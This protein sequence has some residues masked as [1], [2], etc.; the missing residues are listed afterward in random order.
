VKLTHSRRIFE[1]FLNIKFHEN[2]FS[3]S[4]VVPYGQTDRLDEA[5]SRF[6]QFCGLAYEQLRTAD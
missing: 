2:P 4:G 3:G 6:L 5:S 1:K